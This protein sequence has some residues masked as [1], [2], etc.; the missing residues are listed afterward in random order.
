MKSA[1]AVRG[2]AETTAQKGGA[3]QENDEEKDE[4]DDDGYDDDD[5]DDSAG[6]VEQLSGL[7]SDLVNH[8]FRFRSL[9]YV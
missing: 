4:D 9:P 7:Y 5:D 3:K 6:M 2:E 1:Q 8:S